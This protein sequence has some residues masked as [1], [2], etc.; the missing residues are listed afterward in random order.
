[1]LAYG[2]ETKGCRLYDV[3]NKKVIMSRVVFFCE[4][5]RHSA[6]KESQPP[7]SSSNMNTVDIPI[8]PINSDDDSTI[9]NEPDEISLRR[10]SRCRREP[11]RYGDWAYICPGSDSSTQRSVNE[12]LNSPES[13]YWKEAMKT[14]MNSIYDNNVWKLAKLPDGV[15]PVSC[16]W[17]FKRKINPDGSLNVF[18][19]RLVAQGY[20]QTLGI[21]YGDTYSPVIRFETIRTVLSLTVQNDFEVHNMDVSTAFLNGNLTDNIY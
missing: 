17:N 9:S 14:V 11:D 5:D 20:S 12:A 15:N 16:K 2:T 21:N 8:S 3:A 4:Q 7:S 6:E 13:N 18:K 10:S 19:A 1:M